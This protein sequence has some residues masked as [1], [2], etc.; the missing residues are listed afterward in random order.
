MLPHNGW[1]ENENVDSFYNDRN[2]RPI[3]EKNEW[4][5]FTSNVILDPWP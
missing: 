4:M 3:S 5:L 2:V 1:F